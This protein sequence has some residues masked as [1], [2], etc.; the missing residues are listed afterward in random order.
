MKCR[1]CPFSVVSNDR[2]S[3]LAFRSRYLGL[4]IDND[5]KGSALLDD[6]NVQDQEAVEEA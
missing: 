6:G 1:S 4:G 2:D 5:K 3:S